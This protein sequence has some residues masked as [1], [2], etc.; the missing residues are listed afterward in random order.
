[1][2]LA[3]FF[4]AYGYAQETALTSN[5]KVTDPLLVKIMNS[6]EVKDLN[7]MPSAKSTKPQVSMR[8]FSI[9]ITGRCVPET[10][11]VCSHR[12]FLAVSEY[13]EDPEQTVYDLG[14]V[15]EID[16]IEWLPNDRPDHAR[17]RLVVG[18]YP[19]HAFIN[20]KLSQVF[21]KYKM[22]VSTKSLEI[23]LEE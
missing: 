8:L 7:A 17:L 14:T 16:Q 11:W 20:K 3:W 4:G 13:G 15:G 5:K 22:D 10:E 1:M 6:A 21:R 9:P 2:L 19:T 23:N 18:N 12:Y